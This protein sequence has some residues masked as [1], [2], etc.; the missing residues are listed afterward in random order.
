LGWPA[1]I[2]VYRI[3]FKVPDA[4]RPGMAKVEVTASGVTGPP[5]YIP[6]R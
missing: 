2:N 4:V 1:E 6:V 5:S 3:D